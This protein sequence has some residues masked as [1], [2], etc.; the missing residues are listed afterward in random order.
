MK[1][2]FV[3]EAMKDILRPKSEKEILDASNKMSPKKLLYQ[4]SISGWLPG[5]KAALERGVDV[6]VKSPTHYSAIEMAASYGHTDIVEFLL[7]HGANV[8]DVIISQSTFR[9]YKD[10]VE[11]LKK[12]GWIV[13]A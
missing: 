5:V 4:S 7:K 13:R 6:N 10:I 3:Y 12:Y 11:L 9:K 1:A 8:E 2:K